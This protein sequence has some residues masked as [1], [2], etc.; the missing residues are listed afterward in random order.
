MSLAKYETGKSTFAKSATASKFLLK[1]KR[2]SLVSAIPETVVPVAPCVDPIEI[3]STETP[4]GFADTIDTIVLSALMGT[5]DETA[6]IYEL[7]LAMIPE[8]LAIP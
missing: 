4:A 2:S 5:R 7:V 3:E 1:S 6:V 8:T